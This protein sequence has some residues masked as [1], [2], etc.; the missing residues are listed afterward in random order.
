MPLIFPRDG[1]PGFVWRWD[2]T[3][4]LFLWLGDASAASF[5]R[6]LEGAR[7]LFVVAISGHHLWV[8]S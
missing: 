6:G 4:P 3:S 7:G 2:A 8:H 5:W 1:L